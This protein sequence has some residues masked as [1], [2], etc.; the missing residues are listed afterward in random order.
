MPVASLVG[1]SLVSADI[2]G[3]IVHYRLLETTRTYGREKLIGAPN[4]T[5]S[6]DATPSTIE[7]FSCMPTPS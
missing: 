5:T 1:K 3:A 2:G 4:S 6:R 7:T